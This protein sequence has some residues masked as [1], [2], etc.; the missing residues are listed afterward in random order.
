MKLLL[1][2]RWVRILTPGAVLFGISGCLGPNPGFF[3]STSAANAGI[4]TVVNTF[5]TNALGFGG[6]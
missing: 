6:G 4:F 2:R 1:T 5:L 3:I